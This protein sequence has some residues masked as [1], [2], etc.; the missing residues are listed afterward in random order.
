M[1]K[2]DVHLQSET[3]QRIRVRITGT[4]LISPDPGYNILQDLTFLIVPQ[5]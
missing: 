2:Y 3:D 4:Q 5:F 1:Q